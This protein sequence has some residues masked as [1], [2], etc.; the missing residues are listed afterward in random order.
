MLLNSFLNSKG[1]SISRH[2]QF[3]GPWKG[4]FGICGCPGNHLSKMAENISFEEATATTLAALTALQ[5]L[6]P[7][8]KQGDRVLIHAGS[9]GV[10]YFTTQIAKHLGAYV[11]T[12]CS[13]KNRDFVMSL[14]AVQTL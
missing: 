4:L 14:G 7:G 1:L 10:G 11:V 13:E 6:Q 9:G 2:G 5:V 12:T 3:P 8:I